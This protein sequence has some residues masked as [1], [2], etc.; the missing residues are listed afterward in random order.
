MPIII[1]LKDGELVK[2]YDYLTLSEKEI[3]EFFEAK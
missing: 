3:K 2:E 1:A